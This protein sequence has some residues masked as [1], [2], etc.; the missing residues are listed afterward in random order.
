MYYF[1]LH[2]GGLEGDLEDIL[3]SESM[4][5]F[6]FKVKNKEFKAHRTIL[7]ARSPVFLAMLTH[8][9]KE[10][11]TGIAVLEDIDPDVFSRLFELPIQ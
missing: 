1:I 11:A 5:D 4:S 3:R 9:T 10:K 2:I 7:G 8:E 6:T